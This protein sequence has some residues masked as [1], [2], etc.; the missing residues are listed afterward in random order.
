[1][2]LCGEHPSCS[3]HLPDVCASAFHLRA[4]L[5]DVVIPILVAYM[6]Q[7]KPYS[8]S[9]T[10]QELLALNLDLLKHILFLLSHVLCPMLP[11]VVN[12]RRSRYYQSNRRQVKV[13]VGARRWQI[14]LS[15]RNGLLLLLESGYNFCVEDLT[16]FVLR[17]I[18]SCCEPESRYCCSRS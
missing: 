7:Q 10:L 4:D 5:S 8:S 14:S 13:F 1:M 15:V 17:R 9:L 18:A 16:G 6:F 11:P 2:L 3:H 12:N